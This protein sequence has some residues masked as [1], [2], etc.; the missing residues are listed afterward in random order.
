MWTKTK[1]FFGFHRWNKYHGY[2]D[3]KVAIGAQCIDCGKIN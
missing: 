3:E 1:C 2:Y